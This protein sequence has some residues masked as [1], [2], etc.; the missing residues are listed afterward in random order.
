MADSNVFPPT[1]NP[2]GASLFSV[3]T[4]GGYR[5]PK[6]ALTLALTQTPMLLRR[7]ARAGSACTS[8]SVDL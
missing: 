4:P 8:E 6:P 3:T 7:R 1:S 2:F 5:G